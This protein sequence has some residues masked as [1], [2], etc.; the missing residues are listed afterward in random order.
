[1]KY[2]VLENRKDTLKLSICRDVN[3][4]IEK[5]YVKSILNE[6]GINEAIKIVDFKWEGDIKVDTKAVLEIIFD[7]NIVVHEKS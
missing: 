3:E 5:G 4:Q 6:L 2:E 7:R 1:M